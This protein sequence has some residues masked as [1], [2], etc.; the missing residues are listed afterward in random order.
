MSKFFKRLIFIGL[1]MLLVL[2]Y[3]G[4]WASDMYVSETRFSLR[5]QEG[6]GSVE[7][8]ALFGQSTS[9]AGADAHVVQ[10][11]IESPKLL[12]ALD[13]ELQLKEHYQNLDADIFSRLKKEPTR[14]EFLDYFL[15]QVSVHY[16]QVSGILKLQVRAFS[17][18]V[19]QAICQSVLGKS[20]T[21][22][23]HLSE[24]AIEDSLSL[25][26]DEVARSEQR[27]SAARRQIRQFRQDHHLLD[28]VIEAGA[29]QG[30]VAELEGSAAKVR[31]ELAEARSYMQEDSAKVVSFKARIHALEEQI[32]VEKIR[33]T[34]KDRATVS[35]LAAEFEQLTL[36]HEFAQKQFFS[37]MTSLEAA[38]I[39]AE[40][41][42]RY[43]VAFIEP[44]LPEEALWPRR[45][46]SI[47]VSFS[48]ILLFFGLGS[49]I[50]A[51]IR[52]HAGV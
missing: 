2:I 20:E 14:E 48:V 7:L 6:G 36:E 9:G 5:S 34:G 40:S 49:L 30:L 51:A 29:V 50:V 16:E 3:F 4:L 23:N 8:L 19:A 35:S 26:R 25:S 37:A 11:F 28:P 13:Q 39:H 32:Q 1:P 17:P 18:E 43:L 24:R 45:I 21:L 38:R 33:L 31:V 46:Y 12:E 22:V 27:L 42:S 52:E 41:Q 47:G 10:Q 15:K 44:I